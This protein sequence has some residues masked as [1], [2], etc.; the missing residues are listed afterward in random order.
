[1]GQTQFGGIQPGLVTDKEVEYEIIAAFV[2][3]TKINCRNLEIRFFFSFFFFFSE[4]IK[5]LPAAE[6]HNAFFS[7]ETISSL[8][9][10]FF[11]SFLF[12]CFVFC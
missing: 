7:H 5:L 2:D 1:M 11:F 6:A 9:F 4:C 12:F 10:C 8:V 3:E